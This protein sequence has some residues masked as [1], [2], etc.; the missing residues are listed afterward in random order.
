MD[1]DEVLHKVLADERL[2]KIPTLFIVQ[3]VLIMSEL[4]IF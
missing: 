1:F 3:V 2:K 4:G